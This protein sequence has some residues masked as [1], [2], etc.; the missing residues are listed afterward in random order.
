MMRMPHQMPY[1]LHYNT[2][3][4]FQVSFLTSFHNLTTE[5]YFSSCHWGKKESMQLVLFFRIV[6]IRKTCLKA[7]LGAVTF[8][9]NPMQ[10]VG[11]YQN[12]PRA[13]L[14]SLKT[15]M[16][17]LADKK[18]VSDLNKMLHVTN[19]KNNPR[20]ISCITQQIWK[21]TECSLN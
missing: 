21:S 15:L 11:L 1:N 6:H 12:R 14:C 16:L 3:F 18:R 13:G 5:T 20:T 7:N 2:S 10:K 9:F 4:S 8:S 17:I 19:I